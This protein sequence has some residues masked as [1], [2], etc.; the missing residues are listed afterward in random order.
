M[1]RLRKSAPWALSAVLHGA[2]L[3]WLW[4][5]KPPP[6][7]ATGP[8]KPLF[9]EIFHVPA[10]TAAPV[11][12]HPPLAARAERAKAPPPGPAHPTAAEASAGGA[13]SAD[14]P[15]A[16]PPSA[17]SRATTHLMPSLVNPSMLGPASGL[18]V[19]V[20]VDPHGHLLHNRP[21]ELPSRE[22]LAAQEHTV[23]KRRTE[24][25][26]NDTLSER[27]VTNGLVAEYFY[28]L[29]KAL[30]KAAKHPPKID[31]PG[32]GSE[33]MENYAQGVSNFGKTGNPLGESPPRDT[34]HDQEGILAAQQGS[35]EGTPG[36]SASEGYANYAQ[37]MAT[38][39]MIRGMGKPEP[40]VTAIVEMFQKADG[41]L[42][43]IKLLASSGSPQFDSFVLKSAPTAIGALPAPPREGVGIHLEGL[44][45]VW[46]FTGT[47][48]YL[49]DVHDLQKKDIPY[50]AGMGALAAATGGL[51]FDE[52]G[53]V[54]I[55]DFR[56]P[57]YS[58]KVKLLRV[59]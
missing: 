23:V 19:P 6:S 32:L 47:R 24:G 22:Q 31:L 27:R 33:A 17:T 30:S 34:D 57:K 42:E 12:P 35:K 59:Y 8:A 58:C 10:K 4:Q 20:P 45:T 28:D 49:K 18:G 11:K 14:L 44:H 56:D 29:Q 13:R 1:S 39:S 50:A 2:V 43:D 26:A 16:E 41:N 53:K 38:T 15:T 9:V 54:A 46:A 25:W 37:M 3:A 7:R 40:G 21:E 48:S 5:A 51:Q 36:N 55:P 52:T